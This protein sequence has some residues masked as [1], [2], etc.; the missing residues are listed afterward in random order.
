MVTPQTIPRTSAP[1]VTIRRGTRADASLLTTLGA[2]TFRDTYAPLTDADDLEAFI[3]ATF[4]QDL[5]AAALDDPQQCYLVAAV[6]GE[7]V[8]Y[9]LLRHGEDGG[10][11]GGPALELGLLYVDEP[12]QG[13]GV[14]AALMAESI[15]QA[16]RDGYR[17]LRL[18][19]WEHNAR[20]IGFYRRWGFRTIGETRFLLGGEEQRDLVMALGV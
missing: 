14:G 15:A 2:T 5:I 12:F 17:I 20:A 4:R 11:G 3:A 6:A 16:R 9:A 19:V 1:T 13:R 18:T 7:D 10:A 8:G